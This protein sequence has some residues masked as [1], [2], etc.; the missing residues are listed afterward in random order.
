MKKILLGLLITLAGKS[1]FAEEVG[2][3]SM[4][5]R[6]WNVFSKQSTKGIGVSGPNCI[7]SNLFCFDSRSNWSDFFK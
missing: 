2:A 4:G 7:W 3:F 1:V 5:S 6:G